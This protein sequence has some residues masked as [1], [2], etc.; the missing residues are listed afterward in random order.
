MEIFSFHLV[1]FSGPVIHLNAKMD[2]KYQRWYDPFL[3]SFFTIGYP[4]PTSRK[5]NPRVC[6]FVEVRLAFLDPHRTDPENPNKT[7]YA[8][9][10]TMSP[11]RDVYRARIITEL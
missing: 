1:S 6:K 11:V 10:G 2:T 5:H 7:P 4:F 9:L 8:G 3:N